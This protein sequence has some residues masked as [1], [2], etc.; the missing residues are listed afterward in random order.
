MLAGWLAAVVLRKPRFLC[1]LL[2]QLGL[3]GVGQSV[4]LKKPESHA[5]DEGGVSGTKKRYVTTQAG[6][7]ILALKIIHG[8]KAARNAKL[9]NWQG[10]VIVFWLTLLS[11]GCKLS[12]FLAPGFFNEHFSNPLQ[13]ILY[14][15]K[16]SNCFLHS[17]PGR[18]KYVWNA[19]V[20]V[21]RLLIGNR[22][23]LIFTVLTYVLPG[24]KNIGVEYI[25]GENIL[26][27]PIYDR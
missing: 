13:F 3:V 7:K 9:S 21:I 6:W 20:P 10:M 4:T 26:L 1:A 22:H 2:R 25:A 17:L 12:A 11:K 24:W 19:R 18:E 5:A 27:L 16:P 15:F 14:Q 23:P 8:G